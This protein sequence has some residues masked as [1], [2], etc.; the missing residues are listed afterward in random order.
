[1]TKKLNDEILSSVSG[2][3]AD[4]DRLHDL[5]CFVKRTVCNV[6]KYDD[7][8]CLTLRREPNGAIIP[9]IG[10]QNGE[11]ILIHGSYTENGWFFACKNGTYG[12]V[13]P[14]YVR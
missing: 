7:T 14:R 11:H 1:M 12:F 10:W 6:V 4:E 5:S 13:D 3:A 2:G 9:G 8:A